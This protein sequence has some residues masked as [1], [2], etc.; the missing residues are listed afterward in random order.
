MR[1]CWVLTL[2]L[3]SFHWTPARCEEVAAGFERAAA[4][5]PGGAFPEAWFDR[6]MARTDAEADP[7]RVRP[8]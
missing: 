1:R 8:S 6:G 2:I 3:A 5:Q 7:S 4:E